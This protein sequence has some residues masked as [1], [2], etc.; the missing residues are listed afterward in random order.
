MAYAF[1][2]DGGRSDRVAGG[3]ASGHVFGCHRGA[4]RAYGRDRA[5]LDHGQGDRQRPRCGVARDG[6]TQYG[7][8]GRSDLFSPGTFSRLAAALPACGAEQVNGLLADLGVS[9]YQL[10]EPARGFSFMA[11]GPLDMRMDRSTGMTAA[12]VVHQYAEKAIA[13][14]IYQLGEER[15]AR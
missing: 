5:A 14:L 12:D 1:C 10:T 2:R 9:R 6:E 4:G 8:M 15:R 7:R 11:E 3:P 13:D